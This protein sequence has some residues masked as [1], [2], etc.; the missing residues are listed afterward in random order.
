M[1]ACVCSSKRCRSAWPAGGWRSHARPRLP[2]GASFVRRAMSVGSAADLEPWRNRKRTRLSI[3]GLRVQ[4][5]SVPLS[6]RYGF[7]SS[8][9]ERLVETQRA[10]GSIPAEAIAEAIALETPPWRNGRRATLRT[11]WARP[12]GVQVPPAAWRCRVA[13]RESG[14]LISR[15]WRGF[16]SRPC[17]RSCSSVWQSTRLVSGRS[18]GR[19][20]PGAPVPGV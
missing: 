18:S 9:V 19:N 14:G 11:S 1:D 7:C 6:V 10:A 20:R 15:D 13:Q 17:N 5:P 12:V 8:P 4:V 2:G 16:E 3:G